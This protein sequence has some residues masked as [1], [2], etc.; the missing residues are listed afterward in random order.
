MIP[1]SE[2]EYE[3]IPVDTDTADDDNEHSARSSNEHGRLL[4]IHYC[5]YQRHSIL[6]VSFHNI[7]V[8]KVKIYFS[9]EALYLQVCIKKIGL[10]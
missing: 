2:N 6:I 8:T 3:K 4:S 10:S 5:I 1:F 7:L 9:P